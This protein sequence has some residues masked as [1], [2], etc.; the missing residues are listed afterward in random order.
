MHLIPE[1]TFSLKSVLGSISRGFFIRKAP[2]DNFEGLFFK[3]GEITTEFILPVK[4][5]IKDKIEVSKI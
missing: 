2:C 4:L 3:T 1:L 5:K